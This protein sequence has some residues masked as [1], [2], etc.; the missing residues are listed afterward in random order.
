M[1]HRLREGQD[2]KNPH[3][4]WI[5]F[6]SN[7]RSQNQRDRN[8]CWNDV[9]KSWSHGASFTCS[10]SKTLGRL[11]VGHSIFL[12][13]CNFCILNRVFSTTPLSPIL[14]T[15]LLVWKQRTMAA[16]LWPVFSCHMS[17]FRISWLWDDNLSATVDIY[18]SLVFWAD[19]TDDL[20]DTQVLDSPVQ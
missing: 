9:Q 8:L 3:S 2:I 17:G 7:Q 1:V 13:I 12:P 5:I 11:G 10:L 19:I 15:I 18:W 4:L 20:I 6:R 16:V 14:H